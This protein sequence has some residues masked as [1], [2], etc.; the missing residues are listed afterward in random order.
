MT[1]EQ[2][3]EQIYLNKRT[4]KP[5]KSAFQA[6]KPGTLNRYVMLIQQLD[7]NY[8]LYSMEPLE[9]LDLLPPEFDRWKN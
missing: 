1:P 2:A 8:D 6:N 5:K 3:A 7:L 4:K 9:L